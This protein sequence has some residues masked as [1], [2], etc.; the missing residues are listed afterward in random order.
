[1]L[2][3]LS[4]VEAKGDLIWKHL[5]TQ[6]TPHYLVNYSND[7]QSCKIFV[8]HI[9]RDSIRS[10]PLLMIQR[11]S[12][13]VLEWLGSLPATDRP[14]PTHADKEASRLGLIP[15]I[16]RNWAYFKHH[17]HNYCFCT[18]IVNVSVVKAVPHSVGYLLS[19]NKTWPKKLYIFQH[20]ISLEPFKKK[21]NGFH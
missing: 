13:P 10:L 8:D 14:L 1:M 6:V 18:T 17:H 3:E 16:R 5:V 19:T 2:V 7:S 20:T 21:W 11:V 12:F 15:F 4:W 9:L